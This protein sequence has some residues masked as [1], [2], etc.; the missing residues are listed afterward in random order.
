VSTW[1]WATALGD[2]HS[3]FA[4]L[5]GTELNGIF[6]THGAVPSSVSARSV[7]ARSGYFYQRGCPHRGRFATYSCSLPCCPHKVFTVLFV[8]YLSAALLSALWRAKP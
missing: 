5:G 1:F 7:G 6:G 8:R 3:Y 4:Y 2:T